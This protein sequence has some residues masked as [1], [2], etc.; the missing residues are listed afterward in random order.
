MKEWLNFYYASIT[1][2]YKSTKGHQVHWVKVN[3]AVASV[4]VIWRLHNASQ[5]GTYPKVEIWG[6]G[7][8]LAKVSLGWR[9]YYSGNLSSWK[10]L[11]SV[12]RHQTC[13]DSSAI[14]QTFCMT[15]DVISQLSSYSTF[16]PTVNTVPLP[17]LAHYPVDDKGSLRKT[18]MV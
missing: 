6:L 5:S 11:R 10:L 18:I 12:T 17:P 13:N 1:Y 16:S 4:I 3:Y 9:G 2:I 15:T 8:S 7:V 14:H